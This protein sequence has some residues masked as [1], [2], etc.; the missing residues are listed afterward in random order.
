[1]NQPPTDLHR[2]AQLLGGFGTALA[3]M[4]QG[5]IS[6]GMPDQLADRLVGDVARGFARSLNRP[7]YVFGTRRP[8]TRG[9]E[10]RESL[11]VSPPVR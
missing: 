4:R 7:R 1:M 2:F 3:V 11:A 9:R 5:M 10:D 8:P 6:G